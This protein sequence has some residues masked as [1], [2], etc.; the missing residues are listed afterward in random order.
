MELSERIAWLLLG[1]LIG[2]VLGFIVARLRAIEEKVDTVDEH[3][4]QRRR[5]IN[6]QRGF[7][8]F[9]LVADVL[10]FL[11]L[12]IVVW[13]AISAQKASN[14]VKETQKR[15][16]HVVSCNRYYLGAF[17]EAVEPRTTSNQKQTT[18]N[19]EL[20]RAWYRVIRFELHIP[21]YSEEARRAKAEEYAGVLQSYIEAADNAR[22]QGIMNPYPS[23]EDLDRCIDKDRNVE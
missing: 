23:V 17:L 13:G 22:N 2:F 10:Y 15:L 19:V 9:P 14:E 5:D 4:M 7:M 11:V 18:A 6:D 20:Q 21:P 8:R 1:M 16:S 12:I 3:L